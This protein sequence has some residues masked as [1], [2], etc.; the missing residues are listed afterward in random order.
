MAALKDYNYERPVAAAWIKI[1][2]QGRL[3]VCIRCKGGIRVPATGVTLSRFIDRLN[4][5]YLEHR[6]CKE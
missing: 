6:E 5:F 1:G 3:A 2:L 4:L